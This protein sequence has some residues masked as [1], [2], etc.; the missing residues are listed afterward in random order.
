LL[1]K[2]GHDLTFRSLG[3]LLFDEYAI[4]VTDKILRNAVKALKEE[5]YGNEHGQY[6]LLDSYIDVMNQKGHF[7]TIE[8]SIDRIFNR[9]AIV[10]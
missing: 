4:V 1:E 7:G 6:L 5:K 8:T 3:T 10:P 9:L 2:K